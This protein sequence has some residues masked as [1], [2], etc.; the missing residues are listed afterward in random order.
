MLR[1]LEDRYDWLEAHAREK[2]AEATPPR[3]RLAIP[4]LV[5]AL[6]CYA[7]G[8]SDRPAV[9]PVEG[10]VLFEDKPA[11]H[12]L[13]VFH[14]VAGTADAPR[15]TGRVGA[16]GTFSL[17]TYDAGDGAPPGEYAVTVEWWLTPGSKANPAGYDAPPVNRLPPRYGKPETSGLRVRVEAGKNTLPPFKL[18]NG[19]ASPRHPAVG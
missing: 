15:P 17:T 1:Q 3:K 6:A 12:A 10:R 16:D 11:Q 14:P 4:M 5:I 13:V 18:T 19:Q 2:A 9:A 8:R 7:C